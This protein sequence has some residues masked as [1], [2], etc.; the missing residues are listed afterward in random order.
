MKK[1]LLGLMGVVVFTGCGRDGRHELAELPS[2]SVRV[3][4][5]TLSDAPRSVS[6]AGSMRGTSE[7][8]LSSKVMGTVL[9]IRKTSGETVRKGE[10]LIVIDSRDVSGQIAQAKGALAQAKAAAALA[11]TNFSRF[12]QLVAKNAASQLELD[13]AR[14]Q[15]D[16]AKGAVEQAEGAVATASSYRSYAEIPAPFDGWVVDRFCEPGDMAAPGRPLMRVENVDE[17]RL[18][19][20]LP[21][22][23]LGTVASGGRVSVI[24]PSLG[25]RRFEGSIAEIVPAVDQA[26]RSFLVKIDVPADPALRSGMYARA[27]FEGSPRTALR[28]AR[29]AILKRGGM[30]GAFVVEGGKATFRLIT[31]GEEREDAVEVLSGIEDGE[32]IVLDPPSTLGEGSPVEV[33]G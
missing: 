21:E 30:T 14:Y 18:H 28:I 26:T 17:L 27:V 19:V 20:N 11:E 33:L 15:R 1:F 5:A 2:I 32:R 3:A 6:A 31:L 16:T 25:D 9:E 12:E 8:V 22:R 13:Q 29:Q 23:E 7:A 4:A 10:I 24:V